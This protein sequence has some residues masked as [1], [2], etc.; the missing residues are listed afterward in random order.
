MTSPT[1]MSSFFT[2]RMLATLKAIA[3]ESSVTAVVANDMPVDRPLWVSK[4]KPA[5]WLTPAAS[6]VTTESVFF[7]MEC[8]SSLAQRYGRAPVSRKWIACVCA[9]VV[10]VGL[11][12]KSSRKPWRLSSGSS[13]S[14]GVNL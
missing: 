5:A 10:T 11:P 14:V 4:A 7:I 9:C 6:R 8:V 13:A 1:V 12:L 3:V 2:A